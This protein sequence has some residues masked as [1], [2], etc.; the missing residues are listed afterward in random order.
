MSH[1]TALVIHHGLLGIFLLMA[2]ESCCIPIPSEVVMPLAG[3]LASRHL[4]G[5]WPA[6]IVATV[7]NL[8]GSLIA[9]AIGSYA[10]RAFVLRYGRYVGLSAR[11][12]DRAE[13]WFG[14][15]GEATVFFGRMIPAV[16]TFVSLPAGFARMSLA[17]FI[18]FSL[19]G[20]LVWNLALVYGGYQLNRNWQ[21]LADHVKPF[22]Y[23]GAAILVAAVAWFWLRRRSRQD[24]E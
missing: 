21:I 12:L 20:S 5:F 15:F 16:R 13:R 24:A 18:V 11:H 19:F 9:Y 22:T 4:I 2:L 14:R 1:L 7:A 8:V 6:V 3:F 10:G 17:R 23:V